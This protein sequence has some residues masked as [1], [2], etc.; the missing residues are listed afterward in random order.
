VGKKPNFFQNS[1][2]PKHSSVDK[3]PPARKEASKSSFLELFK[4][5]TTGG[6]DTASARKLEK[7][8]TQSL[9]F[10]A[11]APSTKKGESD[12]TKD[13]KTAN[14]GKSPFSFTLHSSKKSKNDESSVLAKDDNG[15]GAQQHADK[16]KS[17]D[18]LFFGIFSSSKKKEKSKNNETTKVSLDHIPEST[19]TAASS[20][21]LKLS[22][23]EAGGVHKIVQ[24]KV[25]TVNKSSKIHENGDT[26]QT[27]EMDCNGGGMAKNLEVLPTTSLPA[28]TPEEE[29][30]ES[31][32]CIDHV[33]CNGDKIDSFKVLSETYSSVQTSEEG[34]KVADSNTPVEYNVKEGETDNINVQL[35]TSLSTQALE[36]GCEEAD[37]IAQGG[38]NEEEC[39]IEYL[40]VT[41]S[42]VSSPVKMKEG[43]KNEE[44]LG[45]RLALDQA[46]AEKC[47]I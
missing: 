11:R 41:L 36:E 13:C 5:P 22:T 39:K 31:N 27:C 2:L 8:H 30:K 38:C 24:T 32:R 3:P 44:S 29:C 19:K 16:T 9:S 1:V 25:E 35:N 40:N 34:S 43:F 10:F 14:F 4:S 45:G 47:A 6:G 46:F 21:G 7:E 18:V 12:C 37:S 15:D 17:S 33:D 20:S 23:M 26:S 28:Q 42:K